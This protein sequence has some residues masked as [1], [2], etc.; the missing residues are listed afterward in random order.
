[1]EQHRQHVD[2]EQDHRDTE[3]A[4]V[5][6]DGEHPPASR[7]AAMREEI[8]IKRLTRDQKLAFAAQHAPPA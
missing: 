1:L 5:D 2:D 4:D 3:Q 7:S 8:R 6:H